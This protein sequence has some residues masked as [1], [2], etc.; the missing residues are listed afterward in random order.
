M[1]D[2]CEC[3]FRCEYVD[4]LHVRP[5]WQGGEA[6]VTLKR[7]THHC[8]KQQCVLV[9]V[10]ADASIQ[11]VHGCAPEAKATMSSAMRLGTFHDVL[12]HPATALLP[13]EVRRQ[14][15][16]HGTSPRSH[17]GTSSVCKCIFSFGVES[18][19]TSLK[20]A[21]FRPAPFGFTPQDTIVFL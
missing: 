18:P 13:C 14:I 3:S 6:R 21:P 15:L 1:G 16:S 10:D 4:V 2:N 19:Y 12:L 9:D 7:D 8:Q 20:K 17:I 11:C 5:T